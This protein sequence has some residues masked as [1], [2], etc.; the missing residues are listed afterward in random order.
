MLAYQADEVPVGDDQRQHV[1][2]MRDIAERFNER[3]APAGRSW[4]SP[5]IGSRRSAAG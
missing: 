2:L 3:F 4:S 1:E 5:S